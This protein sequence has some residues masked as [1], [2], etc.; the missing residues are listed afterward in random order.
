MST[1]HIRVKARGAR[2]EMLCGMH[3]WWR[4]ICSSMFMP[5]PV[6]YAG[7]AHPSHI[8]LTSSHIHHSDEPNAVIFYSGTCAFS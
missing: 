5:L 7:A 4:I 3:A 8:A 1:S 6:C 2:A